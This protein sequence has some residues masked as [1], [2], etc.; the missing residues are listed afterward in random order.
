[1]KHL[2]DYSKSFLGVPYKWGGNTPM[3]GLDCSALVL[4]LLG[5][6]GVGPKYDT[7]AEGLYQYFLKN[8]DK[9]SE[10][11]GSL[12]F[13]GTPEKKTHIGFCIDHFR[14]IEAGGGGSKVINLE[15]AVKCQAYVKM[16]LIHRRKDFMG[17]LM[18][19]YPQDMFNL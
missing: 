13:Y 7:T 18:P 3:D 19:R 9:C 8:G 15:E 2:I 10:K 17:C 5:S 14:M 16:S 4:N 11:P 12:S 6:V 1:M